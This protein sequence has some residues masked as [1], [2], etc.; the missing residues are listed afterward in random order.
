MADLQQ[1]GRAHLISVLLKP[2][3]IFMCPVGLHIVL[4]KGLPSAFCPVVEKTFTKQIW[5]L[6]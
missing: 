5:N 2:V 3:Q 6:A 1:A 4:L